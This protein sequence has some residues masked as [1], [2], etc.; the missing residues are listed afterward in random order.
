MEKLKL[1]KPAQMTWS[2][3]V[4]FMLWLVVPLFAQEYII[5]RGDLL[6]A[7]FWQLPSLNT[8]GRVADDG[9]IDLLIV[10]RVNAAGYTTAK[11][12][13]EIVR[14][15]AFYNTKITQ[16]RVAVLEFGSKKVY[17]NGQVTHPGKYTFATMPTIWQVILESGGP[18]E[19]ANL[20]LITVVRGSGDEAGKVITV[21]LADALN[22]NLINGLP[23]LTPGDIIYV[24]AIGAAVAG[25]TP[26]QRSALV[27]IYGEIARP[28]AYQYEVDTN[29]LQA[30]INAGGP[31]PIADL[32]HV[33]V[34]GMDS[35]NT[36]VAEINLRKYN[37]A[38]NAPPLIL[39]AGDTVYLPKHRS[40]FQSLGGVFTETYRLV[41]TTVASVIVFDL[42]RR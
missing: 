8:Q 41:L 13:N 29:I 24:P 32:E 9:T 1:L 2:W 3:L 6:S 4:G 11:L 15:Y 14:Q 17:I 39:H 19:T 35:L 10:G 31:T 7:T 12:E 36:Q 5:E 28:G 34:V 21:N 38:P 25:R 27:Y 37:E 26:L 42:A 18:L 33:R 30:V 22:R 16:V 40:F 23:K 20:G